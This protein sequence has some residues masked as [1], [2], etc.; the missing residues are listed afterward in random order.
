MGKYFRRFAA[1]VSRCGLVCMEQ[2]YP[3]SFSAV[4]K[5]GLKQLAN[6]NNNNQFCLRTYG[7]PVER[8][9]TEVSAK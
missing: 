6:S 5:E 1:V 9:H 3:E 8:L 2:G 4:A 7:A